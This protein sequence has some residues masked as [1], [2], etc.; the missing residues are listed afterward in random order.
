MP[1]AELTRLRRR[2]R[3]LRGRLLPSHWPISANAA[4]SERAR[5][6][7]LI[8]HAEVET[9][10]EQIVLVYVDRKTDDWLLRGKP[11]NCIAALARTA[12][13]Q[14]AEKGTLRDVVKLGK[15]QL[16]NY[17]ATQNHG[18]RENNLK[19]MFLPIGF[20]L[21]SLPSGFVA[22][23]DSWGHHRGAL[24]HVGG[25]VAIPNPKDEYDKVRVVLAYLAKVDALLR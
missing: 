11:S 14:G 17:L 1:S 16:S 18:V 12:A 20:E 24:A 21:S 15:T 2:V 22:T 10:L 6:F 13:R 4:Q 8:A 19:R 25:Y 3:D 23:L 7:T 9:F 5:G